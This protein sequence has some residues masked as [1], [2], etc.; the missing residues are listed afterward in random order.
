MPSGVGARPRA[1]CVLFATALSFVGVTVV[2]PAAQAQ[3]APEGSITIVK[4]VN[5]GT[6]TAFFTV[7]GDPDVFN[8]SVSASAGDPGSTTLTELALGSYVVHED[9]TD[10]AFQLTD[11]TCTD[12]SAD[13]EVEGQQALITLTA[14][15]PA[16][17]CTF[18]NTLAG[19]TILG[20]KVV[21][22]DTSSWVRPAQFHDQLPRAAAR[23]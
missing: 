10:G 2:A 7:T 20:Q 13:I 6:A 22:G 9:G 4:Q 19:A 5:Q 1:A 8:P 21:T 14:E 12:P 11:I 23:Q 16:V 18:T 15:A 17:T 3:A